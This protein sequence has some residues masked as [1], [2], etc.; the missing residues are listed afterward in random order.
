VPWMA[1][2]HRSLR[3]HL[4]GHCV[5]AGSDDRA[6]ELEAQAA[7]GD[8][9]LD[10]ILQEIDELLDGGQ[11]VE[12]AA[13]LGLQEKLYLVSLRRKIAAGEFPNLTAD[14]GARAAE[15]LMTVA[16]SA[17]EQDLLS[18]LCGG[19]GQV[20]TKALSGGPAGELEAGEV[21]GEVVAEDNDE[22]A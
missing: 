10:G 14:Q 8:E 15:K 4:D 13:L 11:M 5:V 6:A 9:L 20:F 2:H 1:V 3:R 18:A 16:K 12:P 21:V 22:A 7:A 17:R 19:I